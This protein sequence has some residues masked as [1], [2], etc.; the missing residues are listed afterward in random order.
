[1]RF[2]SDILK[3]NTQGIRRFSQG[4]LYLFICFI[5]F[6]SLNFVLFYC[7]VAGIEITDKDSIQIVS[8]NLKW[9]LGTF[10]LY[11]L[12]TKG[13]GHFRDRQVGLDMDSGER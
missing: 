3:E 9:A 12:G 1:M 5:A 13:I 2:F 4:R 6:M 7:A 8:S 11:I 10:A